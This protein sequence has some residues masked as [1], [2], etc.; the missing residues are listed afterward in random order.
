[1]IA[2]VLSWYDNLLTTKKYV[3]YVSMIATDTRTPD[4]TY[5]NCA[6]TLQARG[7]DLRP[8]MISEIHRGLDQI[9]RGEG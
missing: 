2:A 3:D 4:A 1:M 5:R 9:V 7:F 8:Q 6:A